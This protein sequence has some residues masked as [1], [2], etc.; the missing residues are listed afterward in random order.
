MYSRDLDRVRRR[1]TETLL[2]TVAAAAVLVVVVEAAAV[3]EPHSEAEASQD[4]FAR[5]SFRT[6]RKTSRSTSGPH[7][8]LDNS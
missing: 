8:I 7:Y 6:N 4:V 1:Q 3:A 5:S 2:Q